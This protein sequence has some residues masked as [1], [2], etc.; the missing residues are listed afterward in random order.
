MKPDNDAVSADAN[1]ERLRIE[2][3]LIVNA[4]GAVDV[5]HETSRSVDSQLASIREAAG[6]QVEDMDSVA[7]DVRSEERRVGKECRL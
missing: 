1:E 3:G 5:V 4:Q 2:D 7:D 6:T